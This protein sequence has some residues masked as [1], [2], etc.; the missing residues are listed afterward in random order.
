MEEK[1]KEDWLKWVDV[2]LEKLVDRD[3]IEQEDKAMYLKSLMKGEELY[4]QR[5]IY[6]NIDR[7]NYGYNEQ[8][9]SADQGVGITDK[10]RTDLTQNMEITKETMYDG[11][12]PQIYEAAKQGKIIVFPDGVNYGNPKVMNDIKANSYVRKED[13]PEAMDIMAERWR[14]AMTAWDTN[15]VWEKF[16]I[17]SDKSIHKTVKKPSKFMNVVDFI[18][19]RAQGEGVYKNIKQDF[20]RHQEGSYVQ[21]K[22]DYARELNK[23]ILQESPQELNVDFV[24]TYD[25]VMSISKDPSTRRKQL[26]A[27]GVSPESSNPMEELKQKHQE[28]VLKGMSKSDIQAKVEQ[29]TRAKN[30][31]TGFKIY[32]YDMFD[33]SREFLVKTFNQYPSTSERAYGVSEIDLRKRGVQDG[34]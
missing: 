27:F 31:S 19:D 7:A 2:Q 14:Y 1:E 34:L 12:A 6:F 16:G 20:K 18:I 13:E 15:K 29:E 28:M 10:L 17:E 25:G 30:Y 9:M 5:N 21:Y 23:S 33:K 3:V 32:D 24:D 8:F 26:Q 4:D 22:K 11:F